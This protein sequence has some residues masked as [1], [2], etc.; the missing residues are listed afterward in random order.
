MTVTPAAIRRATAL[1]H[2]PGRDGLDRAQH[3][4]AARRAPEHFRVEAVTAARNAERWRPSPARSA[5]G[6]PS[7]A[8]P[9]LRRAEASALAGTGIE[10]AAGPRR[11]RRGGAARP[12]DWVMAGI[13]GAAGL[14]PTLAAV[15]RGAMVALANKEC[16]VCAG[17]LFMREV[18]SHRRDRCC[19]SIPST[20]RSSRRWPARPRRRASG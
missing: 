13:V 17:D 10:A 9:T 5:P 2:H 19:R 15:R 14:R 7:S 11:R 1:R 3:A 8:D 20:T 16:L 6:S 4:G 18:G 12:A